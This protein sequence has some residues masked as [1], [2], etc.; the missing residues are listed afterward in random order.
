MSNQYIV[1]FTVINPM[2]NSETNEKTLIVN[3]DSKFDACADVGQRI[4]KELY[5]NIISVE[6][7]Q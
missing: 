7:K 2:D 1:K 4:N 5:V 3:C 6:L